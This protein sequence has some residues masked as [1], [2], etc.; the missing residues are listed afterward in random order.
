MTATI[1]SRLARIKQ[2]RGQRQRGAGVV[3]P[4]IMR[5]DRRRSAAVADDKHGA[6]GKRLFGKGHAVRL[7]ARQS[8]EDEAGFDRAAVGGQAQNL[9]I[10]ERGGDVGKEIGEKHQSSLPGFAGWLTKP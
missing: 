9:D 3:H 1:F 4:L 6:G 8:E 2:R 7:D 5:G 10:A